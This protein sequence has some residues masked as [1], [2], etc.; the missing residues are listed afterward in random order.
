MFEHG[1]QVLL[2]IKR[3]PHNNIRAGFYTIYYP[4]EFSKHY[5]TYLA[6]A[7]AAEM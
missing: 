5:Y 3:P 6:V 2:F 7:S 4:Q 1:A